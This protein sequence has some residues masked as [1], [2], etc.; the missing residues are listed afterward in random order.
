MAISGYF[1]KSLTL[2][3]LAVLGWIVAGIVFLLLIADRIWLWICRRRLHAEEVS[4]QQILSRLAKLERLPARIDELAAQENVLAAGLTELCARQIEN[5]PLPAPVAAALNV[6]LQKTIERWFERSGMSAL[7]T[8][9]ESMTIEKL[10]DPSDPLRDQFSQAANKCLT[11]LWEEW[12]PYQKY[13]DVAIVFKQLLVEFMNGWRPTGEKIERRQTVLFLTLYKEW[14]VEA[15]A[16]EDVKAAAAERFQ[17]LLE[18]L[19]E[20]PPVELLAALRMTRDAKL[21]ELVGNLLEGP[22]DESDDEEQEDPLM[23]LADKVFGLLLAELQAVLPSDLKQDLLAVVMG[24]LR[25][26]VQNLAAFDRDDDDREDED[27][28]EFRVSLHDDEED[29][30]EETDKDPLTVAAKS[31]VAEVLAEAARTL[32]ERRRTLQAEAGGSSVY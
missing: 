15:E 17:A 28:E 20:A 27:E 12:L 25:T 3:Q 10:R 29:G 11:G 19:K 22:H 30:D 13:V 9:F 32:A 24:G 18:E 5:G 4:H 21:K 23:D 2:E 16:D 1:M 6:G 31:I 14:L 7:A 26:R 8:I